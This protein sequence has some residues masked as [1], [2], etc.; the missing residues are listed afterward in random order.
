MSGASI[1]FWDFWEEE[2]TLSYKYLKEHGITSDAVIKKIESI[3]GVSLKPRAVTEYTPRTKRI[4]EISFMEAGNLGSEY[5]DGAH[6][7]RDI[8]R[9]AECGVPHFILARRAEK[10]I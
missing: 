1:C 3:S 9:G 2:N 10:R 4:L 7:A 8:K 5:I 6:P